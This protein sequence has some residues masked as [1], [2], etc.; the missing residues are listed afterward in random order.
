MKQLIVIAMAAMV[1]GGCGRRVVV[2][3]P[4]P[5]V[6]V[7]DRADRGPGRARARSLKIP[8]GHYPPPGQCRV[9]FAGTPPGHQP[10][11]AKCG[12]LVRRVPHGAF[13]L[14]ND[15]AW[16]TEYDWRSHERRQ[17]GSVPEIVL[18]IMASVAR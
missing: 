5:D 6:V 16:D 7:A 15:A 3:T 2:A 8:P 4:A 17:K 11:P 10:P 9:W 14:Y 13:L 18:Q 12:S 1:L